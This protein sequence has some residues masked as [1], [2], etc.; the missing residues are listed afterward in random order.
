MPA[1]ISFTRV[2][3]M[4]PLLL[5]LSA[6]AGAAPNVAP[7]PT[8]D[9]HRAEID[10]LAKRAEAQPP[11]AAEP[12]RGAAGPAAAPRRA[13]A[14]RW[15]EP[16]RR[17]EAAGRRPAAPAPACTHGTHGADAA[18]GA[19]RTGRERERE[20]LGGGERWQSRDRAPPRR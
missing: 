4:L 3:G 14:A 1:F 17:P 9:P 2:R 12:A 18:R 19:R 16:P 7:P 8:D 15:A 11:G 5:A 10:R 6:A 13:E 20:R